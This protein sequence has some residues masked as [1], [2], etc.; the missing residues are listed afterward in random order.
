MVKLFEYNTDNG[1][2]SYF[3][4]LHHNGKGIFALTVITSEISCG[5]SSKSIYHFDRLMKLC[6]IQEHGKPY[7]R[8]NYNNYLKATVM[9]NDTIYDIVIIYAVTREA[10]EHVLRLLEKYVYGVDFQDANPISQDTRQQPSQQYSDNNINASSTNG[11]HVQHPFPN[12]NNIP[13]LVLFDKQPPPGNIQSQSQTQPVNMPC[14]KV[15]TDL[16]IP[17]VVNHEKNR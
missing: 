1:S 6:N 9:L 7:I 16:D 4:T 17:K 14:E 15:V 11:H 12:C 13:V 2:V 3:I 10:C 8:V 5:T